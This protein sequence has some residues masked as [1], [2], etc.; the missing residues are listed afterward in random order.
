MI[1]STPYF[2]ASRPGR[3]DVVLIVA[4]DRDDHVGARDAGALSTHSSVASPY[5]ATVLELALE[6]DVAR[7]HLLDEAEFVPLLEELTRELSP[8]LPPPAM[9]MNIVSTFLVRA[10]VRSRTG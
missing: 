4:R 9:T 8:T 2:S 7:P 6:A 5:C 10:E 3:S 1:R